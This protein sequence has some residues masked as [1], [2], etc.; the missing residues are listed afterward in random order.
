MNESALNFMGKDLTDPQAREFA[1]EVL[2]HMRD[3]LVGYQEET[4]HLY[5]LEATPGEGHVV[6]AREER[7]EEILRHDHSR[8]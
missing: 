6:S 1:K 5:N 3:R 8:R 7:S 4:G 2:L